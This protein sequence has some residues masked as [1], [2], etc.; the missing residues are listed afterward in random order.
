M[1]FKKIKAH[2]WIVLVGYLMLMAGVCVQ[3]SWTEFFMLGGSLTMMLGTMGWIAKILGDLGSK[4][5][6]QMK[7][8]KNNPYFW[9]VLVSYL[10]LM[11]GIYLGSD[12]YT[13]LV[14]VGI[15]TIV[16]GAA[17]WMGKALKVSGS[18]EDD[19]EYNPKM[20]FKK[21]NPYLW[22]VLIGYL[23]L[24][25]GVYLGSD[26]SGFLQ[27]GGF[28]TMVLGVAVFGTKKYARAF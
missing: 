5:N 23:M 19:H 22:L 15:L 16:L 26:L 20:K 21:I 11:T 25:A 12:Q 28:Y 17:G 10:M 4:E 1:K 18:N 9:L 7:F 27:L 3:T 13:F 2:L 8:Q 14:A 24:M 6:S